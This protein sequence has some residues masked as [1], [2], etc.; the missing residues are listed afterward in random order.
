MK[1]LAPIV[2]FTYKRL[3]TLKHT[4]KA[5]Q[6]NYLSKQSDIIIFS[7][8]AKN[9]KDNQAVKD[10]REYIKSIEGFNSI[11]IYETE[12]N[13]G[14]AN[15]IISGVTKV[16]ES[17]DSVIV[18]EDDLITTPNFLNFMNQTL[19][20]YKNE[21][22]VFSICGYSFDLDV[23]NYQMDSYFLNRCWPWSWATWKNRWSEIDWQVKDYIQFSN[24]K[25]A[26]KKF[27]K[28]GSDVNA[29]LSKQING[30]LDSWAIR[31]T[32]HQFK[33]NSLSLFPV[34][35]KIKNEGFDEFAT[36]TKGSSRRYESKLDNSES[37]KFKNPTKIE[38]SLKHQQKFLKKMGYISRI[39][40]K[41]ETYILKLT[42]KK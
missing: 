16:F 14:L 3:E 33:T 17:Y 42:R 10:V 38:V 31:W 29:M 1:E 35:S 24:D 9:I 22:R 6:N 21:K 37:N 28:C 18:L 19:E 26:K 7:D 36:H 41:I 20:E 25:S 5:L 23:S 12:E 34:K 2:L 15:S 40:S 27:R 13:K 30:K 32:Y 8:G 11:K 4:I 39:K